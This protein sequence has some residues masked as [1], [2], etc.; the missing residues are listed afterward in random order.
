M[1]RYVTRYGYEVLCVGCV[2]CVGCAVGVRFNYVLYLYTCAL[3]HLYGDF[4]LRFC[5]QETNYFKIN[6]TTSMYVICIFHYQL[7]TYV[8]IMGAHRN[9]CKGSSVQKGQP[10][11]PPQ[12]T[13]K[14][15]HPYGE[16]CPYI[17]KKAP[18]KEK[19]ASHM[20]KKNVLYF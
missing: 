2:G 13:K 14:V 7:G 8:Q 4:G 5:I 20:E 12:M 16:K 19:K 9:I 18:H 3:P 1:R 11:P 15:P 6:K 17:E 10:P